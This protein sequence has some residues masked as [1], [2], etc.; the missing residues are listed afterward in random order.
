MA[1]SGNPNIA[2]VD[3]F[4]GAGGLTYGL[5]EAGL[6]V[7]VGYDLDPDCE[8]PFKAN[9]QDVQ[10]VKADVS[11]LDAKEVAS[12]YPD[13]S[14]RVLAG[15]APCQPFS[16]LT[17]GGES[18]EHD[19]WGLLNAFAELIQPDEFLPEVV[20]MENV[21][22]VRNHS[23]Y[24]EFKQH[25]LDSGY[26]VWA[27]S[28]YCPEYG[29]PQT[30]KRW[31]LL[32]SRLGEIELIDPL[33]DESEYPSV[34]DTIGGEMAQPHLEA[35]ESSPADPV[36]RARGLADIN[37][38]RMAVSEPGETWELWVKKDRDELL[39]ACHK[40][41]SGRSYTDPYGIMEWEKPAPTITTQFYNYGSGRFGHPD[42]DEIRAI[43]LREGAMLQTFPEDYEFVEPDDDVYFNRVG[44][45][46]G[47]AVPPKLGES[48]GRSIR[49]H[50]RSM[51]EVR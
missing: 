7:R 49:Q 1:S 30:R 44:R 40:K 29:V 17:H 26:H 38:Q 46:I 34:E 27:D 13:G 31:I 35:G 21:L 33:Y 10:F 18:H 25:L 19:K 11:A 16:P 8:Y 20:T 37:R 6:D 3:L 42:P 47:N 5:Q 14:T 43:S 15:C 23:V 51:E 28:V 12:V 22:E 50:V 39:L 41:D 2:V 24:D 4:C 45:F 32:A 48:I 9:N 36:H